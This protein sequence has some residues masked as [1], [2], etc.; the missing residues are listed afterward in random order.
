M[1]SF[2]K[3]QNRPRFLQYDYM[4]DY[5]LNYYDDIIDYLD[6]KDKGIKSDP[7]KA[8]TW[9]ERVLRTVN[10][11]VGKKLI[12]FQFNTKIIFTA[13]LIHRL[14]KTMKQPK[15]HVIPATN[16]RLPSLI[17]S[18]VTTIIRKDIPIGSMQASCK[19]EIYRVL[20]H[21]SNAWFEW[22]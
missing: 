14:M 12:N 21:K 8:Q 2:I 10:K 7:P 13:N 4:Y 5:R 22:T 15:A 6:K 18:T 3:I 16:W 9:A 17:K 20:H 1:I 11:W 19:H